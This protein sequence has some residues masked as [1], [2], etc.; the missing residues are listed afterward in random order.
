MKRYEIKLMEGLN[1]NIYLPKYS[2]L[3][4]PIED[5]ENLTLMKDGFILPKPEVLLILKIAEYLDNQNNIIGTESA[6]NIASLVLFANCDFNL[7]KELIDKYK[8]RGYIKL[9]FLIIE[10]FDRSLIKYL[11]LNENEF[12]KLRKKYIDEIRKI[13]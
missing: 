1:I 10:K 6:I 5:I 12:A 4:I 13:L 3:V 9:L 11:D 2:K 8:L 7:F